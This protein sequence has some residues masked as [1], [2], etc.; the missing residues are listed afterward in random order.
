MSCYSSYSAVGGANNGLSKDKPTEK[1]MMKIELRNKLM[2]YWSTMEEPNDEQYLENNKDDELTLKKSKPSS[3][4]DLLFFTDPQEYY[5]GH[6]QYNVHEDLRNIGRLLLYSYFDIERPLSRL[7]QHH[8]ESMD[9]FLQKQLQ[10]TVQMFNPIEAKTEDLFMPEFG[11]Y[12]VRVVMHLLNPRL[13]PPQIHESSGS[14]KMMLPFEARLR[15]FVYASNLTADVEVNIIEMVP[16]PAAEIPLDKRESKDPIPLV[17]AQTHKKVFPR[18]LI[19]KI[20]IMVRSGTCVLTENSLIPPDK[21]FECPHDPGGYFIV[22][23]SEKGVIVQE[24][25]SE[26]RVFVYDGKT[27]KKCRLYAEMK[28]VPLNRCVSPKHIEIFFPVHRNT[29]FGDAIMVIIPKLRGPVD[30]FLVFRALGVISDFSILEHIFLDVNAPHVQKMKD[31]MEGSIGAGCQY[32]TQASA[33]SFLENQ[34]NYVSSQ[35]TRYQALQD[36]LMNEFFPHCNTSTHN[37]QTTNK[38]KDKDKDKEKDK[39]LLYRRKALMLGQMVY[40]LLMVDVGL[41]PTDDRDSYFNKRVELTGTLLN[42]LLRNYVSKMVKECKKSIVKELKHGSWHSSQDVANIVNASNITRFLKHETVRNG[43][44]NALSTGDFSVKQGSSKVG[45][46]QVLNRLNLASAVSHLRRINTP[47]DK[48]SGEMVEPRK[49]HPTTYG[50]ICP[51][52]TPEGASIGVVKNLA[53]FVH[54]SLPSQVNEF[55]AFLDPYVVWVEDMD[56]T[57]FAKYFGKP[58]MIVNGCWVGVVKDNPISLHNLLKQWKRS[59]RIGIYT[60][61]LLDYQK[62]EVRLCTDAGRITRPLL[63]VDDTTQ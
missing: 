61:V 38:E 42:N 39:C 2:N 49:L 11:E 12:R 62:M 1:E 3:S 52:E 5:Q 34:I 55:D 59:G 43:I 20:P 21:M 48:T 25:A 60:S 40:K 53:S 9:F 50:F 36:I 28:S 37:Y 13:C 45:V 8:T 35:T 41:A 57:M 10:E 18:L 46:A 23:G 47:M 32:L 30:L 4:Q 51:Y 54:V 24:R 44:I 6:E 33:C 15:G 22:R 29:T 58:K 17:I 7:V 16:N 63:V 56:T 27:A 19:G 31:R 26:N 14:T